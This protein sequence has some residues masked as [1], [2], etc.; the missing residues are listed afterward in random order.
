VTFWLNEP[1]F[2]SLV[3]RFAAREFLLGLSFELFRSTEKHA[4]QAVR[5]RQVFG[6]SYPTA[7]GANF[8]APE[9][10][11]YARTCPAEEAPGMS[12]L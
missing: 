2:Y 7:A 6:I 10:L 5:D 9:A 8:P 12:L 1:N 11:A 4:L 3:Q